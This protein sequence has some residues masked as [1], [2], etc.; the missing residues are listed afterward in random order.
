MKYIIKDG[1]NGVSMYHLYSCFFVYVFMFEN[2][3]KHGLCGYARRKKEKKYSTKKKKKLN[4]FF[5]VLPTL[6]IV[7]KRNCIQRYKLSWQINVA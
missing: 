4:S 7:K 2:H 5:I 6:K 1:I 3:Q